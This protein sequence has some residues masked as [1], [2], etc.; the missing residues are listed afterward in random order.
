MTAKIPTGKVKGKELIEFAKRN[1]IPVKREIDAQVMVQGKITPIFLLFAKNY[2]QRVVNEI[3]NEVYYYQLGNE[4]NH[5]LNP[6]AKEDDPK[7]I[8]ALYKGINNSDDEFE[9]AINL[10][11]D[12]PLNWLTWSS[13]LI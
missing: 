2:A 8:R 4:L 1:N 13:T 6:I 9:S 7:Y 11:I 5:P 12:Y 3:G 10:Y